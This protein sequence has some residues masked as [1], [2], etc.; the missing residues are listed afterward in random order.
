MKR[1]H[2]NRWILPAVALALFSLALA[3]K[4]ADRATL[5]TGTASAE[6]TWADVEP[7]FER[8]C[9]TCHAPN[10][11]PSRLANTIGHGHGYA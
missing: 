8:H 1:E 9:I 6:V 4:P 3:L 7:I 2:Q 5:N 10:P 11:D